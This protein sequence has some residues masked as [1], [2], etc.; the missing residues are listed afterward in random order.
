MCPDIPLPP[1]PVLTRW[2]SWLEAAIF[3]SENFRAIKS[4]IDTFDQDDAVSIRKAQ[5]AFSSKSVA[6]HLAYIKSNFQAI[7]LTIKKM[8]GQGLPVTTIVYL[9]DELKKK[10]SGALGEVGEAVLR[11]FEAVMAKNPGIEKFR[12]VAKILEGLEANIDIPPDKIASLKFAP[13][14]SCDVERTFSVYKSI[15][16]E[17]RTSL[18][19]ENLEK[20]LI[21]N[22][23]HR[24]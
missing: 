22:C 16:D 11:K 5:E 4:V 10:L 21:C 17:K 13:L 20:Y 23:E 8:E 1:Q 24:K 7:P 3:Y 2:S 14:Q 6:N 9:L 12:N 18:T 19:A 15:L